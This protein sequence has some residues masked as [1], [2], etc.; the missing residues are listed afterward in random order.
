MTNKPCAG[1]LQHLLHPRDVLR[2]WEYDSDTDRTGRYAHV[3]RSGVV[4]PCTNQAGVLP[5]VENDHDE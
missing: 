2:F 3:D 5:V 4:Y 1:C